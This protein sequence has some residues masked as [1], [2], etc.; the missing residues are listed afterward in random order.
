MKEDQILVH[1]GILGMRWG[2]RRYQNPDGTLT[3]AG[4]RREA[5]IRAKEEAKAERKDLKWIDKQGGKIYSKA[6]KESKK[7]LAYEDAKLRSQM[8]S[9]NKDGSVNK[10]YAL[11]FNQ[12]MAE[13]MNSKVSD[14]KAPSGKVVRFIA[15]R[16]ELGVHT[17][18]ADEG[19][20]FAQVAK[21]VYGGNRIGKVAYKKQQIE[22]K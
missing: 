4:K 8:P 7:E 16:G 18:L 19:Y 2:V 12:K 11:A 6:F 20:D 22:V 3:E 17:A 14:L 5:K 21:G 15:K 13:L 10:A 9:R 1:W